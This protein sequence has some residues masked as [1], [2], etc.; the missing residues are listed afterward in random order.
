[1]EEILKRIEEEIEKP[2]VSARFGDNWK[3]N[4][5][6]NYDLDAI[7]DIAWRQGRRAILLEREL[8]KRQK[9][10]EDFFRDVKTI[11]NTKTK[12]SDSN[13]FCESCGSINCI[14]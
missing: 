13:D 10:L 2:L 3:A 14:C 5:K 11:Q 9:D 8:I 1:M 4:A 6:E 12:S 7:I